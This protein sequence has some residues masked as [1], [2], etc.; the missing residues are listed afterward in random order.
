MNKCVL[1]TLF[2]VDSPDD[3]RIIKNKIWAEL[4]EQPA[5]YDRGPSMHIHMVVIFAPA[6][7]FNRKRIRRRV[8]LVLSVSLRFVTINTLHS[9][10]PRDF[11]FCGQKD[12]L[13]RNCARD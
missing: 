4:H 8:S 11:P 9:F 13:R 2:Q 10:S 12:T 7:M 5:W 1:R 3:R 6:F